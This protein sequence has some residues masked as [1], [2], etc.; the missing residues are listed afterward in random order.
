MKRRQFLGLTAC[1]AGLAG[2]AQL[3]GTGE[4]ENEGLYDE[5]SSFFWGFEA[6]EEF[7]GTV[8]VDPS[9]REESVEITIVDGEP[10]DSIGYTREERGE[11]CSFEVYVDGERAEQLEVSGTEGDCEIWIDEDGDVDV[12]CVIH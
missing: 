5:G 12:E 3:T 1:A 6:D 2:C 8:R 10:E 9:C 7:S 11:N 4:D